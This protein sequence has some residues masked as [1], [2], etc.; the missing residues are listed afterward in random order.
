[1]AAP[2]LAQSLSFRYPRRDDWVLKDFHLT[3]EGGQF[4]T[5]LGPNGSSKSTLLKLL[6]GLLKPESGTVQLFGREL[7]QLSRREIA[8]RLAYV[9]QHALVPFEFTVSEVVQMGR[10]AFEGRWSWR[11]EKHE[12]AIDQ[13]LRRV[14]ALA[15][16]ERVFQELSGGERQRVLVARALCQNKDL[17]LLDEPTSAQDLEH[18]ALLFEALKKLSEQGCAV[19]V[20]T[21][22]VNMA[23]QYSD[24]VV[25]VQGGVVKAQGPVGATLTA[26]RMAE[27]FRVQVFQDEVEGRPILVPIRRLEP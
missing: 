7:T 24:R 9:P 11:T 22:N 17:L 27:V 15:L 19:L 25:L 10:H 3:L 23:A 6:S 8:Q 16:K 13:A 4:V 26:E 14:D 5:I 2:L 12:Q 1:M 20:V 18:K 21:H